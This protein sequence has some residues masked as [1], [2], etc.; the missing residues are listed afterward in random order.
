MTR[1]VIIAIILCGLLGACEQKETAKEPNKATEMINA[2]TALMS[3]LDRAGPELERRLAQ[4]VSVDGGLLL[5]HTN[6]L[7]LFVLPVS[8]PW[9]IQCFVGMTIVFGNSVTGDNSS[10]D[11][12]VTLG[13]STGQI[14]P[15]NCDILA[16]RI[17]KRLLAILGGNRSLTAKSKLETSKPALPPLL[18]NCSLGKVFSAASSRGQ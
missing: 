2:E 16:P 3:D 17:G 15:K 10:T 5:V 12:D 7:Q 1:Q 8:T 18:A 13:L 6:G 14:E 11:N 9:T 4:S